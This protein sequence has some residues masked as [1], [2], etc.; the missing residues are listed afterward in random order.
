MLTPAEGVLDVQLLPAQGML[1]VHLRDA[2]QEGHGRQ[3]LRMY[4]YR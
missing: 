4:A 1:I 3:L 2:T